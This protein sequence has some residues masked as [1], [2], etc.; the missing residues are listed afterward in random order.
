MHGCSAAMTTRCRSRTRPWSAS[1]PGC[2]TGWTRTSRVSGR[3]GISRER[4]RRG[5]AKVDPTASSIAGCGWLAPSIGPNATNTQLTATE[6]AF[7]DA[8]RAHADVERRAAEEQLRIQRRSNRRLRVAM[9]GIAAL[10][11]AALTAGVLAV[12][13]ADQSKRDA[14]I[15]DD[16]ARI[17]DSR[18]L[19]AQA[20]TVTE[21]DISLLLGVEAV[22]LDDSLA[23][24][25]TL[26]DVLGKSSQLFGVARPRGNPE[27][28]EVSPDGK[29]IVVT[30]TRAVSLRRT[31]PPPWQRSRAD[32]TSGGSASSTAR[33][34][35]NLVVSVVELDE[36]QAVVVDR[37]AAPDPRCCLA[38]TRRRISWCWTACVHRQDGLQF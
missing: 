29:T 7:L 28:V 17:A 3:S 13:A 37:Q 21:P 31:T 12:N 14:E 8:S 36:N 2:G 25:S 15:A 10:L 24:R 19:A 34:G 30:S 18:R 22:R 6:S 23:S 16:S 1:G 20:L 32:R 27:D 26:Y 38:R 4:Q 5:T 35:T 11:V 9:G 33:T